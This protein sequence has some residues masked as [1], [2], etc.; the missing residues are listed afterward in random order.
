MGIED[1]GLNDLNSSLPPQESEKKSTMAEQPAFS[2]LKTDRHT[3]TQTQIHTKKIRASCDHW[4]PIKPVSI[5]TYD[6]YF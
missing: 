5:T 4:G 2:G 6:R 3:N 1:C